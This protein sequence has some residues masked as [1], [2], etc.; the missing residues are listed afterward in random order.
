[1]QSKLTLALMTLALAAGLLSSPPAAYAG[2]VSLTL[3]SSMEYG[4]PGST[5]TFDATVSAPGTNSADV[6]LNS[7]SFTVSFPLTLD[8][9]DYFFNFPLSLSPGQ[10]FSDALFTVSIPA[11]AFSGYYT[12]FFDILGGATNSSSDLL[13]S[14]PFTVFV[15]PEP[16]S[17]LLFGAGIASLVAAIKLR[18]T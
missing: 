10:S 14:A 1:M 2:T 6:F 8:D 17:F 3:T 5:E 7:D 15:T 13:A 12:G 9:T 16:S 4:A 18:K 11:S